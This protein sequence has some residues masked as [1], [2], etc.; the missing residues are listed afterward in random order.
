M[1]K[2]ITEL[3]ASWQQRAE[4]AA[5]DLGH[6]HRAPA[7]FRPEFVEQRIADL[8]RASSEIQ[9]WSGQS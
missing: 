4:R 7:L 1:T 8:Q 9:R 3:A 2:L 5:E 6:A